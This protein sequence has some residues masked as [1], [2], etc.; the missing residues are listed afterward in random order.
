MEN[1]SCRRSIRMERL[2]VVDRYK[3]SL[4]LTL[5]LK[6][7]DGEILHHVA[8]TYKGNRGKDPLIYKSVVIAIC[9]SPST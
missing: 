5:I 3:L 8:K 4:I 2:T 7:T 1:K 9:I 6:T